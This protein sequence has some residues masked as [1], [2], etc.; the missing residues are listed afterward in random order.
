M[1]VLG[2]RRTALG[3][4]RGSALA[5]ARRG[6]I[7]H[8]AVAGALSGGVR[9]AR[10]APRPDAARLACAERPS[11]LGALPP[12]RPQARGA[13]DRLE[14]GGA[15]LPLGGGSAAHRPRWAGNPRAPPA[16]VAAA[17]ALGVAARQGHLLRWPSPPRVLLL[18]PGRAGAP[19]PSQLV[20]PQC[21]GDAPTLQRFRDG[22][23]GSACARCS[24]RC[25]A[26]DR[27]PLCSR[28]RRSRTRPIGGR[29]A[30]DPPAPGRCT[31]RSAAR[32]CATSAAH[33]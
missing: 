26:R 6:P 18:R 14:P 27:S 25:S 28:W 31:A 32:R 1:A 4:H 5:G 9:A 7:G 12:W 11:G 30:S 22:L 21:G 2:A 20:C 29:L 8:R 17:T 13:A 16:A 3:A 23:A 24:G 33:G 10:G 19:L 15:G